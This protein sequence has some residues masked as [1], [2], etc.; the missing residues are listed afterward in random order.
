M[1][2]NKR[3]TFLATGMFLYING[4]RLTATQAEASITILAVAAGEVTEAGL[5]A[6][7]RAHATRRSD[8]TPVPPR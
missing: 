3:A 5:A 2:G 8:A 6:W 1:D 4:Y 7:V